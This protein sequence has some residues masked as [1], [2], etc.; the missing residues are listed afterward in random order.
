MFPML[1][2]ELFVAHENG[3]H[4]IQKKLVLLYTPV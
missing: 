2:D 4:R 1:A 3:T